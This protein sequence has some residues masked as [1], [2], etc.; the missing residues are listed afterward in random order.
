MRGYTDTLSHQVHITASIYAG[1]LT[2]LMIGIDKLKQKLL[3]AVND[4]DNPVDSDRIPISL[5]ASLADRSKSQAGYLELQV[6]FYNDK[7]T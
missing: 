3:A 4:P 6:E 2:E 7:T 5:S 1:N